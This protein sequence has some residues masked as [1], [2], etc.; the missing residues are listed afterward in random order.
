M[1][2][3]KRWTE[4]QLRAIS[5]DNCN[6][7]VAAAAG[8]GKT[9]VLVERIIRKMTQRSQ[10]VDIDRLLIVTF[11]NAAA[12][13]MRERIGAA[14]N[15][16][17]EN[18][19]Q[20][21]QLLHRQLA[22][23]G[24]AQITTI[25]SF[26]LEV[27]RGYFHYIDLDP[28]FRIADETESVLL[29]LEALEEIFEE[30]Y[31]SENLDEA[32]LKLVEC[33]S[34]SKDDQK[35]LDTV[36]SIYDF[37]RSHPHPQKWLQDAAEAFRWTEGQGFDGTRWG[38]I[39]KNSIMTELSGLL[40]RMD[41][42]VAVLRK[43]QGLESYLP[44]F[45]S[46]LSMLQGLIKACGP[47]AGSWHA[48]CRGFDAL[49]FDRLPRAGK[50]ADP[51]SQE[52]VKD[53]RS[54]VKK[55]LDKIK[56]ELV[57]ADS[58]ELEREL[59]ELYPMMQYLCGLVRE[60][61]VRYK[62][63]KKAKGLIDFNDLEHYCLEILGHPDENGNVTATD[64]ARELRQRYEEIYIDEYQDSNMI[65]EVILNIL[66]RKED[67]T[68]N[69]FMVGD[70]KQSIYRFR[71]AKP[72]LFIEKYNT[73]A[74][75]S[76]GLYRK[77]LLYKNFRSRE[78]IIH[79]VNDLFTQLMSEG[80]GEIDY[81]E[82]EALRPGA[83]FD[84]P[85]DEA[86]PVGGPVEL[87]IIDMKEIGGSEPD[88]GADD[89]TAA[90][91]GGDSAA[92][93]GMLPDEEEK[94]DNV[95]SEAI[96]VADR[97]KLLTEGFD[98]GEPLYVF[99]KDIGQYRPA[100]YKDI[101]ILLRATKN[102]AEVFTEELSLRGIP[103]YS[104]AGSGYFKT[105]EVMTVLSL[106]QIIDNPMQDI[107]LLSVLRSPIG[108]FTPEELIDIRLEDRNL[109]YHLAL[110]KA[111]GKPEGT[112]RKA[113]VFLARLEDWRLKA[114]HMLT[115]ELI[116][117][118]YTDTGYYGYVGAMPGGML[119]QANLRLLF[120]R[121]RQYEET[122][123]KGL[124]SFISFIDKLKSSSG[125]MGSAKT[126]GEKD[127]V[128]R[129]MSIHKS[130]GL[131][132]PIVFV[133]GMGKSFNL[134]D[135]NNA[136]L[137]HQELGF[138]PDYVDYKR[139]VTYPTPHK[140]ALR[141]KIRLESLSEEMR[142]LYVAFTR[143][144]EKLILTGTVKDMEKA[145]A[146]WSGCMQSYDAKLKPYEVLR[147]SSCLDWLAMALIRHKDGK[148]AEQLGMKEVSGAI[149]NVSQWDVRIWNR[150]EVLR[151]QLKAE[152]DVPDFIKELTELEAAAELAVQTENEGSP[153]STS[154]KGQGA[155]PDSEPLLRK[156]IAEKLDWEYPYRQSEILPV[157]LTVTELKRLFE[158]TD[159]DESP[160]PSISFVQKPRY[161]E[162]D[163]G[164]TAAE[165][166][167][168][169]HFVMQ[170]L[171][172]AETGTETEI[173]AQLEKMVHGELLTQ[174]QAETVNTR[175][176]RRFFETALGSR[177]KAAEKLYREA[178][179]NV[180]LKSTEL[181]PELPP[182]HYVD[183]MLLLQGIIDCYFDEGDGLVLVDYKTDYVPDGDVMQ[184]KARYDKQIGYYAAALERITGKPVKE[185]YIYLFW[186]GEI[187][188]YQ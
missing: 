116:W 170:H 158:D 128:V 42:A 7:L 137:L 37:V 16:L 72:E 45:V 148:L 141:Y 172:F 21:A 56:N 19:S 139:R 127:D 159:F 22:L 105:V 178:P 165:K 168:V 115:N 11:T 187:I 75:D 111:A 47:E 2:N 179:F 169:M 79:A 147:G 43:A 51:E 118:L 184:I 153:E 100:C 84:A 160:Q 125:D 110:K 14:L 177:M 129:I 96:L 89:Q 71:Q 24:R 173:K 60:L 28:G 4:E 57:A 64:A 112:G 123:L 66:S 183:E 23:L 31:E 65:Q 162:E 122:S 182:N 76:A 93:A 181:Y 146:K 61:D 92:A 78:N 99:D 188:S 113:A 80:I 1:Q 34:G 144:K 161:L 132:F 58:E 101:V 85:E 12:A 74:S 27:I 13:E 33:Y 120:D 174:M 106:L 142:I 44:N 55:K 29:K 163:T 107:P 130:K 35:L 41:T 50:D 81:N 103:V 117:Y 164:L 63:K 70:V 136:I 30:R 18:P 171:D 140:Q 9:A 95:R 114:A 20:Q 145:A 104:D 121:A 73:Y 86:V 48:L 154:D 15:A 40:D 134:M 10:P 62:E 151:S 185:K 126:L 91:N 90:E 157:K 167:T 8:A 77:I 186:N 39:L 49:R 133:C 26:C 124:F 180:E 36:L 166:G 68:P 3:N 152:G 25:H 6:L 87:H 88:E 67:G 119:R 17:L 98:G 59:R 149:E 108:G 143:A 52:L 102:W 175:K 156:K 135:I 131:E 54:E 82:Q 94:P 150:D 155:E 32:F 53:I 97:I 5:E 138:G 69:I 83:Q 38:E 109:P 176:I 46:E